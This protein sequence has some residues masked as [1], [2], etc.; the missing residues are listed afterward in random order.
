MGDRSH[1]YIK[2]NGNKLDVFQQSYAFGLDFAN[3]LTML[4]DWIPEC[5]DGKPLSNIFNDALHAYFMETWQNAFPFQDY[6]MIFAWTN[7]CG[8]LFLDIQK[9]GT[10][11]YCFTDSG[12]S[13]PAGIQ[14]PMSLE[15]YLAWC[16][17]ECD[18][19]DERERNL[20]N[21]N[22]IQGLSLMTQEE[23]NELIKY[24][25]DFEGMYQEWLLRLKEDN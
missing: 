22:H 16:H 17:E 24:P 12:A 23:L 15:E 4:D 8:K 9:D 3:C 5:R 19:E 14:A 18:Y 6:A 10:V 21:M 13:W 25:Y 7:Q 1:I 20:K 2:H 11:K